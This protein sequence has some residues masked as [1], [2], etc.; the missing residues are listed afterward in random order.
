[1]SADEEDHFTIAQANA[2]L[3]E[4]G[5]FTEQRVSSRRNQQFRL[6]SVQRVDYMDVAPRQIVGVSAALIP[7]LEHDDANRALMGSNMQRQ[8]VPCLRPDKPVDG[9]GVERTAAVDSG[10]VVKALRGGVVDYV[11]ASRVVV[12]VNDDEA[13]AGQVGVD[14]YSLTKYQRSN[15]N[16]NINQRPL[17]RPGD[18]IARG[19]VVA[20][21]ASTDKGELALGQNMMVAFM[22][23]NGYNFEDSILISERVVAEDRYTSI[24]IEELNVVARDTKLGPE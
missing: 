19:D 3:D 2:K 12:R 15:Q 11:D 20:D 23:W 16:T 9:T 13:E 7:F 24:H 10:T 22:P 8:A 6:T 18:K 1:M 4:D 17:V 5:Q 14:I 21:G